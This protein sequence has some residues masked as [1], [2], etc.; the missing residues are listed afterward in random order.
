[1]NIMA[2]MHPYR[3][4]DLYQRLNAYLGMTLGEADSNKVFDRTIKHP[5]ITGIAGDVVEQSILGYPSDSDQR[6]DLI[7]DGVP[8]ELKVTGLKRSKSNPAVFEAKEPMSITAVSPRKIVYEDF[9][10]SHFWQ[11]LEHMLIVYYLYD[12]E[13]TV[14][15]ADYANFPI[16]GFDFHEFS[17]KD[18]EIL[19]NDWTIVRDF[20]DMLQ[21][22]YP[23]YE[24]HYPRISSELRPDLLYIDTAPKW[25][26][27]PRFRLKRSVVTTLWEEC[28]GKQREKLDLD[29]VTYGEFDR[30]CHR[31]AEYYRHMTGEKILD[32]VGYPA[33]RINKSIME[34]V[35]VSMFGG[36]SRKMADI[37]IFSKMGLISK[38]IV[39]N[40]NG[41]RTEDTKFI[42]VDFEEI[43]DESVSFEESSCY[44]HF[45]NGT[46]LFSIFREPYKPAPGKSVPL[47][48][49]EFL[50]FKRISFDDYFV[51]VEVRKTWD[52]I[53]HLIWYNELKDVIERRKDGTPIINPCGTVKSA[54]NFP[55]ASEGQVFLRGTSTD[56]T[57]KPICING[58][59]MTFQ[60]YWV[61]G[62]YLVDL[63]DQTEYL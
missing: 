16:E 51:E 50:G 12:S 21:Q 14:K 23:N 57:Y 5:K 62:S 31:I 61:R 59:N 17:D 1:M 52:R 22:K 53:R 15:A 4:K 27:A 30:L 48:D 11:K 45:Y 55:K 36:N 49:C 33:K 44:D 32:S 13:T 24:D 39:L 40:C 2:E 47:S 29:V 8:T 60:N 34:P 25:P 19:R 20:I 18:V 9:Y 63:L 37:E 26:H 58:V 43:I 3:K 10:T 7:V 56:S 35:V 46:F 38:T 42:P 6:P 41:A 28:C 54:P